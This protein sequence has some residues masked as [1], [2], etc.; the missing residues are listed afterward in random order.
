MCG[1]IVPATEELLRAAQ[2]QD[3]ERKERESKDRIVTKAR[4]RIWDECNKRYEITYEKA[5][6]ILEFF[7]RL[8]AETKE[9]KDGLTC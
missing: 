1:E 2:K 9:T 4:N 8:D 3:Q 7:D 6:K 5:A